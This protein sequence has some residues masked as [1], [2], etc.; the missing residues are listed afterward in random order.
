M[1][2]PT[3]TSGNDIEDH[4]IARLCAGDVASVRAAVSEWHDAHAAELLAFLAARTSNLHVARDLAQEVWTSVWSHATEFD[5]RQ[6][7][8]WLFQIARNRLIDW[9]RQ[10]REQMMSDEVASGLKADEPTDDDGRERLA[11]IRPCVEQLDPGRRQVVEA[12]LRGESFDFISQQSGT[13]VKTAMT[14]F[15][16]AKQ[17]LK[18]CIE[19]SVS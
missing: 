14:Q 17:Q 2:Q 11:A 8:G 19:R 7:R 13:P 9:Q 12:R 15:H 4:H 16:R 18:E 10:R 1:V 5:G 3:H 6:L